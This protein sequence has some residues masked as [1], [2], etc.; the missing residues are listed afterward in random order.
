MIC[1]FTSSVMYIGPDFYFWLS[2]IEGEQESGKDL[3]MAISLRKVFVVD[4]WW[5]PYIAMFC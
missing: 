2:D 3:F 4:S 1:S 5:S